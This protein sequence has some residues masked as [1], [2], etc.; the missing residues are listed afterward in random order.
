MLSE[1][2]RASQPGRFG[3]SS[4]NGESVAETAAE[5]ALIMVA[6]EGE[7]VAGIFQAIAHRSQETPSVRLALPLKGSSASQH[8][9]SQLGNEY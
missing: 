2:F 6:Q 7:S 1:A 3:G 4:H 9:T 5:T 8:G